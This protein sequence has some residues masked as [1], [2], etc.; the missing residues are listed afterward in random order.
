MRYLKRAPLK[1]P[2]LNFFA[3]HSK[4]QSMMK[5]EKKERKA[6]LK[7]KKAEVKEQNYLFATKVSKLMD[8][9]YRYSIRY[10]EALV[11]DDGKAYIN[12][13]LTKV[14][15]PF[16]LYSYNRR[17][18]PEI[19]AYIDSAAF[20]LRASVPVVINFDDGGRYSDELKEKIKK[21]VIRH[22]A[23]EFEDRMHEHKRR[24]GF[25]FIALFVGLIF[26]VTTVLLNFFLNDDIRVFLELITI[27]SWVFVWQSVDIFFFAGHERRVDIYNS[28]Q[29][30]VAEV[31]FGAPEYNKK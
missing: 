29:L 25:G 15:T 26:L 6:F 14:E 18:D 23:L 27:L 24:I 12:V 1:V 8:R 10:E 19:Y 17:V 16:S 30:A 2:K 21:A 13:D 20:Y 11:E 3:L 7:E 4:I 9:K 22:Y 28:A 5:E 31:R